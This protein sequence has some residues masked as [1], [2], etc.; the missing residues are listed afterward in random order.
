[1]IYT[2]SYFGP[3]VG[4]RISIS[5]SIPKGQSVSGQWDVFKPSAEL[6]TQWKASRKDDEAWERYTEGFKA[7]L[8]DRRDELMRIVANPPS[9]DMTLLCWEHDPKYCHRSLVGR[10]LAKFL[11]EVWGGEVPAKAEPVVAEIKVP[12]LSDPAPNPDTAIYQWFLAATLTIPDGFLLHPHAKVCNGQGFLERLKVEAQD[13]LTGN[14][15]RSR[16]GALQKDLL[17][18]QRHF[19]TLEN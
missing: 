11:P 7:L 5:R 13:A 16:Y 2:S 18:L 4:D 9:H 3:S 15:P 14:C 1:M 19:Q 17:Q 12:L 10:W 6:L 8:K